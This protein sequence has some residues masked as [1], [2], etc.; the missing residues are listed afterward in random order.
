M[1]NVWA[2]G[3]FEALMGDNLI[4]SCVFLT[5]LRSKYPR[6]LPFHLHLSAGKSCY[7][8]HVNPNLQVHKIDEFLNNVVV[9]HRYY[10]SA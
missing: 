6:N 10:L 5:R 4:A 3:I 8:I 1:N 9:F 2:L 7:R